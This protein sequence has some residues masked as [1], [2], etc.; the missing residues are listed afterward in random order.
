M[1]RTP[2]LARLLL[3]L[4]LKGDQRRALIL[5][6]L[7]EDFGTTTIARGLVAARRE[8]WMGVAQIMF[9]FT[10]EGGRAV[11]ADLLQDIRIALRSF[12]K[13]P[14]FTASVV[15]TLAV[16]I[17][18]T[19]SIFSVADATL[20]RPLPF[21][22]PDRL[23]RLY[24]TNSLR[25]E[26]DNPTAGA[27]Y[28]DWKDHNEVFEDLAGFRSFSFNSLDGDFPE[29]VDGL[30]VTAN[31]FA[32][33]EPK[34]VIGG[35]PVGTSTSPNTVVISYDYWVGRF[36]KSPDIVGI[37]VRLD[38]SEYSVAAVLAAEFSF[39]GDPKVFVVSPFR[40]PV[41]PVEHQD[42]S[43]DRSAQ[44]MSVV[45]RLSDGI[46]IEAAQSA[47]GSV[48]LALASEYP[49][50]QEGEGIR[51]VPLHGDFV[52]ET[53]GTLYL[54]LAASALVM[55]IACA[56]VANLASV[57]T[58][59]RGHE[60][61]L[62]LAIGA[63]TG[64]IRR[65]LLTESL[66]LAALGIGPG[67]ALAAWSTRGLL[68][69]AP[70]GLVLF[71]RVDVN[72]RVFAFSVVLALVSGAVVGLLPSLGLARRKGSRLENSLR[73]V[74][75]GDHLH[76]RLRDAAVVSEVG[77]S[78]LLLVSAGLMIR[79]IQ[80]LESTDPG[81]VSEG[82]LVASLSLP[83]STY[84]DDDAG[85]FYAEALDRIRG[86]RGVALASTILTLPIDWA[87]R[88]TFGFSLENQIDTEE[89]K[90]AGYQ[91]TGTDYFRTLRIPI[92][93]GRDFYE[94]DTRESGLVVVVND[95][96]V[97]Q[98]S[99]EQEVIGRRLTFWG[100]PD[101]PETAWATIIGVA[102]DAAKEGLDRPPVA[103]VFIPQRQAPMRQ[104]TFVVRTEGNPELII[105][106]VRRVI[107][108]IDPLVPLFDVVRFD[109]IVSMSLAS[110]RFRMVL[111]TV[112]AG[113][114]VAMAAV[115]LFGVVSYSVSR[116][117]REIG[118]FRAL[119]APTPLILRQVIMSGLGRVGIGIALGTIV[120]IG[121]VQLLA[122]Q[123]YGVSLSD[124]T[125]YLGAVV[126]LGLLSV[127]ACVVPAV[128]ASRIDPVHTL[129]EE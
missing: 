55:A 38:G 29:R 81:F 129:R 42:L 80:N 16:G 62:R 77:L 89:V 110:R 37:P 44:F 36:G 60:L 71:D 73:S 83:E 10:L 68:A 76:G 24:S 21:R 48:A 106:D 69:L 72:L 43:S 11:V 102:A 61:A 32:I 53:R 58:S 67:I 45:G 128:R 111:L 6:D 99:P 33:L 107:R 65:Q 85:A 57:R 121:A 1:P 64:R 84:S 100:D 39:P 7:A 82:V 112:F 17:G 31:F 27:T 103:E 118:I 120:S 8:Y 52:G 46:S 91:I 93:R 95:R 18:A 78:L 87:L 41:S 35:L 75:Q 30:S 26:F 56:N 50:T 9:A 86:L 98:F 97:R 127:A 125:V 79:T 14:G 15:I 109:E 113:A 90:A 13:N 3:G 59:K 5:G 4:F 25:S 88:G 96:F 119:G 123:V 70:P 92:L 116:R 20:L 105:P 12:S 51:I 108:S 63:R 117:M 124:P 115:G 2:R 126:S 34:T 122:S 47:M 104:A 23:A 49:E 22:D 74:R 19:T 54:L 66:L 94:S 101:D 40:V 114:A 28:L